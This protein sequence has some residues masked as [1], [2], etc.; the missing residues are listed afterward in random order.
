LLSRAG[1]AVQGGEGDKEVSD[2][3]PLKGLRNIRELYRA[4]IESLITSG[5]RERFNKDL[6][7]AS[8]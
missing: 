3:K 8:I 5:F 7:T 4:E 1:G 2:I 6:K